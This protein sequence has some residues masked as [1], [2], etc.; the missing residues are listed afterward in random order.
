MEAA[1]QKIQGEQKTDS[2]PRRGLIDTGMEI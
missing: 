2:G 1:A